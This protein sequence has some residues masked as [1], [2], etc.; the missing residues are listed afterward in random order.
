MRWKQLLEEAVKAREKAYAPYSGYKV[1]AALQVENGSIFTGTNVENASIGLSMCA[2]RVAVFN[3]VAAGYR[4]FKALALVAEG[5]GP[6]VP[7]GA[8]RQVLGEFSPR[9]TIVMGS[10][11][12]DYR[13]ATLDTLL[14][15]PFYLPGYDK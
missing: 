2:E 15:S 5:L 9:L 12:G 4:S 11:S 8:C 14:P 7:C 1:G 13:V 6:A 3:A 10:T